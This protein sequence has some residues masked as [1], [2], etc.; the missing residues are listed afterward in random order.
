MK[1]IDFYGEPMKILLNK[2]FFIQTSIGGFLTILTV[3]LVFIF[4][5]FI[6]QDILFKE[7]P[8]SYIQKDINEKFLNINITK[9]NFPFSFT[10]TDDDN[11][12]LVDFSYLT[13]KFYEI[14]YGL[15]LET[16][17]FSL[18]K[19]TEHPYKFCN[20]SDFPLINSQQFDDSQLKST[21][22]PKNNNFN[23]YGYWNE[24]KVNYLQISIEGC[25]NFTNSEIVCKSPEQIKKYLSDTGANL[26]LYFTDSKISINNNTHPVDFLT[27][28]QYK[29]VIPEYY[30]KTTFKIQTENILTDNGFFFNSN[31]N[32]RFFKIVEEFT[33]IR[34]IDED[35]FQLLVF[36]IYSS[37][38]S[39]TYFRRYIKVPDILGSLGGILKIFS[40]CFLYL[41]TIFSN[42]EKNI[43]IV[44]EVFILN[45]KSEKIN[46]GDISKNKEK[47]NSS[48]RNTRHNFLKNN[49]VSPINR[50][51]YASSDR[52]R[53]N[54]ESL[55]LY[56]NF[57]NI[58]PNA[59]KL[60]VMENKKIDNSNIDE[61]STRN[62]NKNLKRLSDHNSNAQI[63][64]NLRKSETKLDFTLR[65]VMNIICNA[66]CHRTIPKRMVENFN[67]YQKAKRSF[68][69]YFD[70][71]F[72][73]KKFEEINIMKN[74]LFSEP[75]S[76]MV[77]I[78][79]KPILSAK[80]NLIDIKTIRCE[81]DLNDINKD[82]ND[83][84]KS[85]MN[86]TGP[87]DKSIMKIIEENNKNN[88]I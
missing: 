11:V 77:E 4:T 87:I 58:S 44:N 46:L 28:A 32:V 64:L 67:F 83:F 36:E 56:K 1:N 9:N 20:Y 30:K 55:R 15:D 34:L 47:S 53:N 6:G 66:H 41:N 2:K 39:E 59:K 52:L 12:P 7:K 8:I 71:I 43:S 57:E 84:L 31:E 3:M 49:F 5:W 35:K 60:V 10:L 51:N 22:C 68:E 61:S 79:C 24:E 33:D 42:V 45:K 73:I 14:Q 76:K 70:F 82:V 29:Y 75:Q 27:A 17:V 74:C 86:K 72:M 88:N 81:K 37:N 26:N 69:H 65:D 50:S 63:Y 21:L 80:E 13:I 23:L 18:L 38:I 85:M 16:E 40:I 19:R 48:F 54:I 25:N 62:L 78:M